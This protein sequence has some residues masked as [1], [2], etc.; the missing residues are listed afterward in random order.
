MVFLLAS[1]PRAVL[2]LSDHEIKDWFQ[3][4]NF[5]VGQTVTMLGRRFLMYDCDQFTKEDYAEKFG[6]TDFPTVDVGQ[7]KGKL[8]EQ[9]M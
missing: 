3:P 1:F 7:S 4:C 8:P 2:E 5:M 9:V 6:I